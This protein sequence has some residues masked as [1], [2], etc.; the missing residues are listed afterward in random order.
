MKK[1]LVIFI[2]GL[3]TFL[4][5]GQTWQLIWADEFDG[6]T[7]NANNWTHD[8]GTG[9]N[10]WGNN[11]LQSYTS[12][13][14]NSQVSNGTLKINALEQ[15]FGQ[16]NYTSARISSKNKFSFQYGKIEARIKMPLGQGLWPA[17]WMLGQNIDA[18][19]WP[20]CGEIDVVEHVNNNPEINGTMHW[21]AGGH[22]S[23][24]SATPCDASQFHTYSVIWDETTIR[25]Y[26]DDLEYHSANITDSINSTEEFHQTFFLILN[27]AVGG[28]WPG[29][30]NA[31]TVFPATMEV[32]YVRV[33]QE[34]NALHNVTFQV[35][36]STVTD[37]FTTPELNGT[38]NSWCGN[39]APMSDADGD[40]IWE[41]TLPLS[42]GSYE[43]KF[44]FDNWSGQETLLAGSSC[45]T[46]NF[47]YTNRTLYA[48]Q[49]IVLPPVC[50]GSCTNCQETILPVDVTFQLDMTD[51]T[52]AYTTPELNGTFNN[53]CGSCTA[54]TDSNGD[55]IW[56]TTI[57]LLPGTYEYKFSTDN[58]TNAETL[59]P[60]SSCTITNGQFTN[61]IINLSQDV[62]LDAVC[63]QSCSACAPDISVLELTN[64]TQIFPNPITG[65]F[66][67]IQTSNAPHL[68]EILDATGK[69]VMQLSISGGSNRIDVTSLP[70]GV[71][72]MRISDA[73]SIET[74][75]IIKH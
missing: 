61:R 35:D 58:W 75:T 23:W 9:F 73:L 65:D 5:Q 17:F 12:S 70:K 49:D 2:L 56:E 16:S 25:W 59:T 6:T 11:E 45:T 28:N 37:N 14:N 32:D 21:D 3:G 1:S 43:Y 8:I 67:D 72:C 42:T 40:N 10:G 64:Q 27:I 57:S 19:S 33:Y 26:L 24:G 20:Q 62:V 34:G 74:K 53:W 54:M 39:C 66:V 46:T 68:I 4:A 69:R 18:V 51:F 31:S 15:N 36:M 60:G 41:V 13:S 30:P 55:E 50:F 29:S 44:S 7:I 22:A 48:Q 52:G 63:W 71:Y 47:G 38:F